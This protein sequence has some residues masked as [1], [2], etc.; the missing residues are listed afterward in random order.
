M[1][2][3]HDG[4]L[5]TTQTR[6]LIIAGSNTISVGNCTSVEQN[7]YA[8][9]ILYIYVH[10]PRILLHAR[11]TK[12]LILGTYEYDN[13]HCFFYNILYC[14]VHGND[15]REFLFSPLIHLHKPCEFV[16]ISDTYKIIIWFNSYGM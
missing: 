7:M 1:W 8:Y 5:I 4:T 16:M 3:L 10:T 15:R 9:V 11:F 14:A 6:S 12:R 13:L 2:L